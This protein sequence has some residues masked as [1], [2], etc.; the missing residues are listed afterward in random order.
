[1]PT[2]SAANHDDPTAN[3]SAGENSISAP[4]WQFSLRSLLIV[5]AIVSVCLAIGVHFAGVMFAIGVA[6]MVQVVMLLAGDWLIRPE[7]RRAL[8]FV[9]AGSWIVLGSGFLVVG[10]RDIVTRI[11]TG[12]D[13]AV[14]IFASCLIGIGVVCYYVAAKRWRRLTRPQPTDARTR[15]PERI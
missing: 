9:T 5:T 1:M 4:S 2:H 15:V 11:D 8:A 13:S 6:A 3:E 7:N 12:S 14:W 10:A